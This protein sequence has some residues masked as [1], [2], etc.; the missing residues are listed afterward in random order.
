M[1]I[2]PFATKVLT[3]AAMTLAFTVAAPAQNQ[4][5]FVAT[6]G[7]DA[8]N[9]TTSSPCRTIAKA[10]TVTK[11]AGEVVVVNSGIYG[12]NI[13]ISSPVTISAVGVDASLVT[14]TGSAVTID[15]SPGGNVT[16]NGLALH[17][18]GGATDSGV[19]VQSVTNLR[20]SNMLIENFQYNGIEFNAPDRDL[21]VFNSQL[22]RN[23]QSGILVNARGARV[24]V[25]GSSFDDNV[26]A[27][28]VSQ[29]G[30][31]TIHNSSAHFN[32]AGFDANGGTVTLDNDRVLFNRTGLMVDHAGRL[33][34]AN[35]LISDN[36][37]AWDVAGAGVLAGSSPATTFVAP[38][39][40]HT[41]QLSAA[42]PL[43]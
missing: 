41:G 19:L 30:K 32:G 15:L 16:I 10:L 34:F 2:H 29:T 3:C 1:Q 28:A 25:D 9:C 27:G 21:T 26:G 33:R 17:A 6:T 11:P 38:G 24:Y 18:R 31:L 39:Q 42:V 40:T 14:T 7:N 22:N 37:T 35:C 23:W 20:L 4:Q 5:S 8:S 13:K 43:E 12:T 36:A